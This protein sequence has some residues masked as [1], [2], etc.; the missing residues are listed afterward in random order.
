MAKPDHGLDLG[1]VRRWGRI[2]LD[3]LHKLVANLKNEGLRHR[4]FGVIGKSVV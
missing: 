2:D 4:L 1:L 3:R